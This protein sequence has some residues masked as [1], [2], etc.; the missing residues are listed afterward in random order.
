MPATWRGRSSAGRMTPTFM[1]RENPASRPARQSFWW[2]CPP[3]CFLVGL[4]AALFFGGP[5][6]QFSFDATMPARGRCHW[7]RGLTDLPATFLFASY[8]VELGYCDQA[9]QTADLKEFSGLSPNQFVAT[10]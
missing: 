5:A 7:A 2:A 4:P 8:A 10:C 1:G 9:N 3:H 6:R